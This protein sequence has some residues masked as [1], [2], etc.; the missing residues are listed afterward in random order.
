MNGNSTFKELFQKDYEMGKINEQ[1]VVKFLNENNTEDKYYLE[2]NRFALMDFKMYGNSNYLGELKS[3]NASHS[4][5]PTALIGRNKIE[6]A[7]N[8]W[9]SGNRKKTYRFWYLYQ[10][11]LFHWDFNP[12]QYTNGVWH[13]YRRGKHESNNVCEIEHKFLTLFTSEITS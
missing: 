9:D 4:D 10:D 12:N 3:R 13:R 11:G 1:R 7:Q 2:T 8:D 5:Y 6:E